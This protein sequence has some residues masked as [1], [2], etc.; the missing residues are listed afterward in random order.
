MK[1]LFNFS[2]LAVIHSVGKQT[3]VISFVSDAAIIFHT[4]YLFARNG[5]GSLAVLSQSDP[6]LVLVFL[7]LYTVTAICFCFFLST[8][9]SKGMT[10]GLVG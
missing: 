5:S 10:M 9:F 4:D 3:R 6:S 7:F 2:Q 8:L 1:C